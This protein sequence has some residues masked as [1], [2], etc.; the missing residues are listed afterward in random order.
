MPPMLPSIKDLKALGSPRV[1]P[2]GF[3][4]L[5]LDEQFRLHVWHPDLPYRQETY[6]PI[7]DHVFDFTSYI[8]SGRLV[9]IVYNTIADSK[10]SHILWQAECTGPNESILVPCKDAT[11]LRLCPMQ[12]SVLQPGQSYHFK[13]FCLHETL[14][15][16]PTMTI[17]QKHGATIY[18]GNIHKPSIAVPFG[19]KADN[20]FR[21]DAVNTD[22]L[23]NLISKAHPER[24]IK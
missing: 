8:Y 24:K 10:G 18:Q 3:I 20:K 14:S 17:M 12:S 22:I 11:R 21:R 1:H 5:D 2:N 6:H 7:H 23:W 15:N 13:A 9:H 19:V 4:Q 16:E